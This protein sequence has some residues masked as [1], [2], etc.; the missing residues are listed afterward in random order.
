MRSGAV[1]ALALAGA[2]IR[3]GEETPVRRLLELAEIVEGNFGFRIGRRIAVREI[4]QDAVGQSLAGDCTELFLDRFQAGR[5]I[6]PVR[7][8]QPHRGDRGEPADRLARIRCTRMFRAAMAFQRDG[9]VAA[10]GPVFQR[11]CQGRE[12]QIVDPCAESARRLFQQ[13]GGRLPVEGLFHMR[14]AVPARAA[15][16]MVFRQGRQS[17]PV[18]PIGGLFGNPG[19][20]GQCLEILCPIEE[21]GGCRGEDDFRAPASLRE[22]TLQIVEKNAPGDAIHREVMDAPEQAL[23]LR[24]IE[25]NQPHDR[26]VFRI[27]AAL[28]MARPFG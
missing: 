15:V 26:A 23:P 9:P 25:Q 8:F 18:A 14:R 20:G 21:G 4:A 27:E 17:F 22:S 2:F 28:P 12:Q 16:G 13:G 6:A 24:Q 3:H 5:Q 19:A 7:Q 1:E 10:A 11:D